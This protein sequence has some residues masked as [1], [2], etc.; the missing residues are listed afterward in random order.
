MRDQ[1]DTRILIADA[2]ALC[3]AGLTSVIRHSFDRVC[4]SEADTVWRVK[5][6]LNDDP[7][8]HLVLLDG[9]LPGLEGSRGVRSL[10]EAFPALRI[11]LTAK[12]A[13][14]GFVARLALEAGVQNYLT[15]SEE[16]GELEAIIS[17][18]LTSGYA[19]AQGPRGGDRSGTPAE[20]PLLQILTARQRAI[21]EMLASGMSNRQIGRVLGIREGTVK[22]HLLPAYRQMGVRN[23]VEAARACS[24]VFA[25]QQRA[26]R[27]SGL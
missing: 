16:D 4:I 9:S 8:P 23:R 21:I 24:G 20:N 15:G 5:E 18:G 14:V 3:V 6:R 1:L 19:G 22:A 13:D 10:V 12:P 7:L 11:V 25:T 26:R 17:A 27:T 2:N